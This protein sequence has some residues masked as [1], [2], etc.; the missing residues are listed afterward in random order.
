MSNLG[1][2][3]RRSS[4]WL[5]VAACAFLWTAVL[6]PAQAAELRFP[7]LSGRVV[8][9][10]G[11][12]SPVA[13]QR[14]TGWLAELERTKGTQVVV[15]TVPN[16]QGVPIE[17]F[18]Y[19]L[20]RAWGIGE[21]GRNTG[22]ILLVAPTERAVR[23]E[24]GYGLE[25]TLTDALSRA[26]IE[27]DIL[28]A[29]RTAEFERGI[30]AGT[31]GI[32]R[33]LGFEPAD[34]PPRSPASGAPSQQDSFAAMILFG[35]VML[36]LVLGSRRRGRGSALPYILA[37]WAAGSMNRRGGRGGG[38]GGFSGGGGSFGGGGATGRW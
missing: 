4:A 6:P 38:F 20:G 28:P 29:F 8:D 25:G 22:A 11:L 32:L 33:T 16:L 2:R 10:A 23:I 27:Q 13:E 34:A 7:S 12:L 24:V 30:L 36:I 17:D 19:Q 21:A 35:V 18:G 1:R 9:N 5:L 31:A 14:L 3:W 15:V 26:I 37:G